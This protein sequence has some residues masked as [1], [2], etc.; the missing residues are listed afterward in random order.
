MAD[1]LR[2][3]TCSHWRTAVDVDRRICPMWGWWTYADDWCV[4]FYEPVPFTE[5]GRTLCVR[6][7]HA[8]HGKGWKRQVGRVSA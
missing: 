8:R 2:C 5:N 3:E 1:T 6:C 7:H 4:A